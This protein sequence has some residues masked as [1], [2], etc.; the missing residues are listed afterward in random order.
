MNS[1][2]SFKL[3]KLCVT[4]RDGTQEGVSFDKIQIRLEKLCEMDPKLDVIDPSLVT[5]R[6]ITGIYNGV[7]TSELDKLAAENAAYMSSI[8]PE[9]GILA[10][11][12]AISDLQKN[13]L[14]DYIETFKMMLTHV[15]PKTGDKSPLISQNTFDAIMRHSKDIDKVLDYQRDFNF[16]FFGFKTLERS[17]L[18]KIKKKIVERPQHMLL[19]VSF[20]IF[21]DDIQDAL[22]TYEYISTLKFTVATPTLFN[23]GTMT[24]Q[25]SSC[26]LLSMTDDSIEGIYDT[27]KRCAMI[28]KGAGG[29]GLNIHNIRASGSYIRGGQ[30]GDSSGIVP[31]L[32]VYND[33]ARYVDQGGGKRKGAFAI[34]LEPWHPDVFNFLELKLNTGK[35]EIR[36]RDLYYGLWIPDLFMRRVKDDKEWSLF[37]PDECPGLCDVYGQDFEVLYEKYE[38][39][40]KARKVVSAQKLWNAIVTSQI[41]T[42]TPYMLYKDACNMKSNQKNLGTIRGSNLC[43]EII[44][45]TD[46]DEVAVCNLSSICLPKFVVH[47]S[48][49]PKFDY[50]TFFLV[51]R[52]AVKT[53]NAVI[54][55]NHYPIPEA[56]NSNR[57][58]R[59]VGIGVQ[60]LADLFLLM[61]FEWGSEEAS[62]LNKHIFAALYYAALFESCNIA[63]KEGPYSTFDGSPMSKGILQFDMWQVTPV[64]CVSKFASSESKDFCT[65]DWGFLKDKIVEFG[66]RNSLLIAPMPTAS[67]S[68]IMGNNECIEPYTSNIFSRRTS[69]GDFTVLNKHLVNDLIKRGLWS[70]KTKQI[71]VANRGSVQNISIIPDDLKS[72]YKTVWE[73][74]QK[75]LVNMMLDRGPYI[76]QNQSFN[77]YMREPTYQKITSLHFY[78]WEFG[79]KS[80]SYYLRTQAAVDPINF[81]VDNELRKQTERLSSQK[82]KEKEDDPTQE[83]LKCEYEEDCIS[84]SS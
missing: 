72:L 38:S 47:E 73:I 65:L 76:D 22:K 19:R 6:T 77:V 29:I 25:M 64:E 61:R 21:P 78:A 41:E 30:G 81:T 14:D 53:L 43:T 70:E 74:P 54:D 56:K 10:S 9:Y 20:G 16:D 26:F 83:N 68:Q 51:V 33:T 17:Y 63:K 42:G 5:I 2:G 69:A 48:T 12:I 24:P 18:T 4:K 36:A 57:K 32:R 15:H 8:H 84:C 35:E 49:G 3:S 11:R 80:S 75:I 66:T 31:M 28:S 55:H 40:G 45:Y 52:H 7:K 71:I 82:G 44:E 60:G 59:P 79:G 27:L 13:T 34:Y 23:A 46:P 1:S 50:L 62:T 39:E 58:H 67:T 37:C